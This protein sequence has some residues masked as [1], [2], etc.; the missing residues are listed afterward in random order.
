MNFFAQWLQRF[1]LS[2]ADWP[3]EVARHV[4]SLPFIAPETATPL[5]EFLFSEL[6]PIL[7]AGA[8]PETVLLADAYG[9]CCL[10]FW[11]C[12]SAFPALPENYARYLKTTLETPCGQRDESAIVLAR[13]IVEFNAGDG[14]CGF[15]KLILKD[16]ETVRESERLNY[17]GR[18]EVYLKAQEKYDEYVCL[19]ENSA[20]FKAEWQLIKTTYAYFLTDKPVIRRSSIPERNWL[21]GAEGAQFT[22]KWLQF[23][24]VFDFFCWKYYLWGM[25]GD[26]PMLLK[27]SAV[28]TPHGTQ[29]FIPGYLSFDAKRDL[30]YAQIT[31]LHKARGVFHQG[32]SYSVG[33]REQIDLKRRA[34]EADAEARRQG[35]KGDAR[36]A[37]ICRAIGQL[38]TGDYRQIRALLSPAKKK[39][40]APR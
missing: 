40:T 14:Q 5:L 23:K 17:Q 7:S 34:K 26:T 15:N 13:L 30:D 35:L 16:P 29:I 38:D 1:Q 37:F 24:A 28:C 20:E 32:P 9:W 19:L 6:P 2:P 10:A 18:Y 3:R 39:P 22:K 21:R 11:Q 36:Y 31:K 25:N 27:P 33:R 12:E 4:E 8:D